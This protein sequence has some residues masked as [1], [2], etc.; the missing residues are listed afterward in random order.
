M[1][2]KFKHFWG[3]VNGIYF[4]TISTRAK[5]SISWQ[6]SEDPPVKGQRRVS[7]YSHMYCYSADVTETWNL[8]TEQTRQTLGVT[9]DRSIQV[10]P[11][12]WGDPLI[13]R[14]SSITCHSGRT[15]QSPT[16]ISTHS[17][18]WWLSPLSSVVLSVFFLK[19]RLTQ[20]HSQACSPFPLIT[21][22]SSTAFFFFAFS[23]TTRL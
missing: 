21:P 20:A 7:G 4:Q 15:Q 17:D 12:D 18:M 22:S 2:K 16:L 5:R 8:N 1:L 6:I 10:L 9:H 14:L 19:C 13:M 3:A 23:V 11:P